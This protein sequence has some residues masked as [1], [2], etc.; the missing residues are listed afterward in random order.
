MLRISGLFFVDPL[1]K[2]I[3]LKHILFFVTVPWRLAMIFMPNILFFLRLPVFR[4]AL[5]IVGLLSLLSNGRMS[6]GFCGTLHHLLA[7]HL[8]IDLSLLADYGF[9][10][11]FAILPALAGHDAQLVSDDQ[12]LRVG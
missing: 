11:R 5:P 1:F 3:L 10:V 12:L 8:A 2:P 7:M 4:E 6:M 9:P